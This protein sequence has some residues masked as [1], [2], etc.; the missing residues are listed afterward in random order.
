MRET[1]LETIY[2]PLRFELVAFGSK[3]MKDRMPTLDKKGRVVPTGVG[4]WPFTKE[5]F[6]K[7]GY[8][9]VIDGLKKDIEAKKEFMKQQIHLLEQDIQ[10][11]QHEATNLDAE[12]VRIT[13]DVEV[14]I[15]SLIDHYKQIL[16]K[17]DEIEKELL[18]LESGTS[19]YVKEFITKLEHTASSNIDWGTGERGEDDKGA[20]NL[21]Q[22][23]PSFH[24]IPD[25]IHLL[26]E[27]LEK[28]IQELKE[29][30]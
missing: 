28:D 1:G 7:L 12:G 30:K 2:R 24:N 3:F 4:G 18:S 17:L 15:Q 5:I 23:L 11:I 14:S 20:I 13:D 19:E 25:F 8:P 29:S 16:P 22:A 26:I 10:H 6:N 21:A 9:E 27:E